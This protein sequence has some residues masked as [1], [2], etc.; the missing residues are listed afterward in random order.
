[1]RV[2]HSLFTVDT[3]ECYRKALKELQ[4]RCKERFPH[5]KLPDLTGLQWST[6][7]SICEEEWSQQRFDAFLVDFH[8]SVPEETQ[9]CKCLAEAG[10]ICPECFCIG[11]EDGDTPNRCHACDMLLCE[12]CHEKHGECAGT[13][14]STCAT[15]CA[16][17]KR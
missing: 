6:E 10:W 17:K 5:A 3:E 2:F 8:P 14:V 12:E 15:S 9:R 16:Q 13:A 7:C 1:M 11:G 4:R